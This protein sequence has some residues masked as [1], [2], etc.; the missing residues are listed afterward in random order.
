MNPSFTGPEASFRRRACPK[1]PEIYKLI[2]GA[3][4]RAE[5][6]DYFYGELDR[7]VAPLLELLGEET[8]LIPEAC[9]EKRPRMRG[10]NR[11]TKDRLDD[12]YFKSLEASVIAGGNLGVLLG[13]PSGNLC[14]VDLDRAEAIEPFLAK[15]PRL[16]ETLSSTGS[17]VGA[18]FWMRIRGYYTPK[19]LKISVT[20]HLAEKYGGVERNPDTGTYDIGEWRGGQK[21]TIWGRHSSG[22][23]YRILMRKQPIEIAMEEILLPVGWHLRLIRPSEFGPIAEETE[24][25][26]INATARRREARKWRGGGGSH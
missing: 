18:Q 21:S 5:Y 14:T 2:G 8:L 11:L 7:V 12:Y 24:A 3:S 17:G 15:N 26:R 13:K 23:D 10:W 22:K 19:V 6:W 16:E 4:A 25:G 9:G 1:T 20:E